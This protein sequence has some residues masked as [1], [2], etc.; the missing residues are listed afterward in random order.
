MKK[1]IQ[2]AICSV[3]ALL[4]GSLTVPAQNRTE[5]EAF[6]A[7]AGARS[8]IFRGKQ[9]ARYTFPANGHPYWVQPEY[10]SGSM[11][12][13][14]NYYQLDFAN[15]DACEQRLLVKMLGS[16]VSVALS[17]S[18]VSSATLGE[19]HFV[20]VGP[21]EGVPEGFYEVFGEGPEQV[22]KHV[23]KRLDSSV[24]N[25]N[26]TIIGYYDEN[27]RPEVLRHFSYHASYYFRD[28]A[29]QFY[30]IKGR[31]ALIR[32]FPDRKR[33]IRRELRSSLAG[34]PD[35]DTFCKQVLHIA[36]Q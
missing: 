34:R 24:D 32:K 25:V 1:S 5:L 29:G 3:L 31:S 4:A 2:L 6:Q 33:E 22:Y 27:Y 30:P 10:E 14:G 26:G 20:G 18:Q 16:P 8:S 9:A 11:I 19:R 13:E 17:P 21:D 12:F 35:Y 23:F 28:A 15:V 7:A 36:A